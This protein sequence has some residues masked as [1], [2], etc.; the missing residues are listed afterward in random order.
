MSPDLVDA[1]AADAGDRD[2]SGSGIRNADPLPNIRWVSPS[3]SPAML[4]IGTANVA[5][6][7][8]AINSPTNL[9]SAVTT[10]PPLAPGT[11]GIVVCNS[12]NPSPAPGTSSALRIDEKIPWLALHFNPPLLPTVCSASP[13]FNDPPSPI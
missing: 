12:R 9:P 5:P 10:G 2:S 1:T 6:E 13:A 4:S 8:R 11:T 7:P 3:A